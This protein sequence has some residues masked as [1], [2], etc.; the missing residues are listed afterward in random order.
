MQIPQPKVLS[1]NLESDDSA[2]AIDVEM[3]NAH[4]M[5]AL[6]PRMRAHVDATFEAS[7]VARVMR[8]DWNIVSSK[9][10][11]HALDPAYRKKN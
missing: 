2:P 11:M 6:R 7:P 5:E 3:K 8:R 4:R 9:L 1:V 10:Y